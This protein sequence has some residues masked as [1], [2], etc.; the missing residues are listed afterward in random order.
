[1]IKVENLSFTYPKSKHMVLHDFSFSL[2]GQ[3]GFMD[4]WDVMGQGNQPSFI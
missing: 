3:V 1:M 4:C 2:E